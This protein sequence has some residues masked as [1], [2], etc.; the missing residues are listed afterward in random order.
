VGSRVCVPEEMRGQGKVGKVGFWWSEDFSD[1]VK[2][3][4]SDEKGLGWVAEK[5]FDR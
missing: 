3:V 2:V 1:K 4:K 5:K